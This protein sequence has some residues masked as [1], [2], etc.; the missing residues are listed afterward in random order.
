MR[1]S[2]PSS[3]SVAQKKG[4]ERA[5]HPIAE[6]G[7][8]NEELARLLADIH[9][10]VQRLTALSDITRA[11]TSTLDL[12]AVLDT[13]LEKIDF[14]LPDSGAS[15]RLLHEETCRL[16]PVTSGN[17]QPWRAV[18]KNKISRASRKLPIDPRRTTRDRRHKLLS[19]LEV[20]L[21]TR[22]EL[23]GALAFYTKQEHKFS[24]DEMEFL[25]MLAGQA[26][27]AVHNS[28]LYE[29]MK[30]QTLKFEKEIIERRQ[31][32][33]QLQRSREQLRGL[34]RHLQS[35]REVERER[36]AREIHD[37]LAQALTAMKID[38][39]WLQGRL[40]ED[41]APMVEK[42]EAMSKL[43]DTTMG[44]VRRICTALRPA[45]LDDLGL[46][47]AIKWQAQEFE[48]RTGIE[49]R[50]TLPAEDIKLDRSRSTSIFRVFQETLTNVARHAN[51]T[52]VN[53]ALSVE[54][55][56]LILKVRDNGR[57]ITESEIYDARSLGLLGMRERVLLLSGEFHIR[58]LQRKGTTVTV[59]VPL[60]T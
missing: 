44:T 58:G 55:E 31:V 16:D 18:F 46:I 20:P 60:R 5:K 36:I 19:S 30:K 53:V 21:I 40:A 48:T 29:R 56:S 42:T 27:I 33:E 26:A 50:L 15:I 32:E 12:R 17:L 8:A 38:L 45:I 1:S 52:K 14:L 54:A 24:D 10:Y 51:A 4:L 41:Q 49:C 22:G 11:M 6:P 7:P 28:Q 2:Q 43:I 47:A 9:R 37:E 3:G 35:V 57:G 39:S 59:R 25:S 13:L 23:L 34:A